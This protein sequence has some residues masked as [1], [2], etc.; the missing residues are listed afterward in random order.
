[1]VTNLKGTI[2]ELNNVVKNILGYEKEELI[3]TS[4][5]DLIHPDDV[6]NTLYE[7]QRLAE[8]KV[9]YYFE[10]RHNGNYINLAWSANTDDTNTLI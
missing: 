4:V 5:I 1:M 7:Q 6:S 8:G 3:N 10:N 2:L 9:I